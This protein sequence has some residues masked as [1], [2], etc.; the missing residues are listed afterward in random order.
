MPEIYMDVDTALSEVPVNIFPLTDDTDFKTRETAVAYNAAGMDLVW[1]FVTSAG[2]FTQ[3]AVTPT[4]AGNYDWTHQGDG[5]YTIEIPASG[6]ASINN[7]TEGYGWFSGVAT[8]VLPWRGPIIG[9]RASGLND[10]LIDSAYS[11]TRG[12][13]GTALPDAA[14]DAAGGLV[15]SD[16]GGLD[17]DAR[18]DVAVSSRLAPTT[19]GRTLDV[20]TGGEAGI[21][22]ANV[23]S[24]STSVNLS[25]TT[26]NL[27]NTVTTY[28][29]NTPQT[30]DSYAIVNSGTHGNAALKT[31]IDTLTTYV[32]TEV[33]D[34]GNRL[35]AALTAG[36]NMK[37]DALAFSGST[38]AADNAE[39]VFDTDFA[40]NY[41]A[42]ADKWRA[43]LTHIGAVAINTSTAQLGVNLVNIA[44]SAV[45]TSVGQLGVNVVDFGGNAG[46]FASGIPTANVASIG[47]GAITSSTF[48][49]NSIT[50]TALAASVTTELQNGLLTRTYFDNLISGVVLAGNGDGLVIGDTGNDTTHLHL[51]DASYGD[52]ELNG[53]VIIFRDV[54]TGLR[55]RR[56]ITDWVESTRLATLSAALPVTPEDQV[57]FYW[58]GW[59]DAHAVVNNGTYGNSALKTLIDSLD[60]A[61]GALNDPSAADIADAVWEETIADHSGTA[62]ST[63]EQLAAAGAAGDPWATA[64]P[65]A[66]S[67]GQ[68]GYILGTNL[69]ATVSSRSSHTAANVR[70][71]MDSNSTQLAAIVADTNE[72]QTD[73]ANGGRLDLLI[74]AILADTN[75]LQTNQGNWLTATGFSTHSA[76]DVWAVATRVLT[77]GTNIA[78]A[79]GTGVTGFND[80]DAAGI[81]SAV[82]LAS[83]NLDTQ[84]GAIDTAIGALND[85]TAAD[86]WAAGTRTLTAGTNIVLAK[87]TGITGFNDLAAADVRTALGMASADLDTQL[88]ALAST[89]SGLFT[90]QLTESYRADQA[91]P[92]VAQALCELLAHPGEASIDGTTKT[93]KKFDGV[94]T[95][96]TF[97]LDSDTTPTAITRLT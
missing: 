17:I 22:W 37:C 19:A 28:T 43:D 49:A 16:A 77:A 58:V 83:A 79:K 64:V 53:C 61:V 56:T 33:A 11:T 1:N 59:P 60:T 69:N 93:L 20:S 27:V 87:G 6:G 39:V 94:T 23:G 35:P 97:E 65:G 45:N 42:T 13:A 40:A 81:R 25:G 2:A 9:F 46:T 12:L 91:A 55:Y 96:M 18:L 24:Q 36:G 86:V 74:D 7:D 72:L 31:L 89:L 78:L 75:E 38:T 10:L 76:A 26:T 95:A 90:T 30:G 15:I 8:G 54:S 29:G 57:D 73:W 63:A 52:D 92:T 68:A 51:P 70:S 82:G 4:T 41:N 5:M 3:T 44:G 47:T 50:D 48:A 71:E 32:D 88:D 14:A 85:I 80:L 67:A 66:Y 34:I 84:I 62:G 21:D